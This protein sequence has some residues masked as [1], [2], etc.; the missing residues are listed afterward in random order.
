MVLLVWSLSAP[1]KPWILGTHAFWWKPRALWC[2]RVPFRRVLEGGSPGGGEELFPHADTMSVP[3]RYHKCE[4]ENYLTGKFLKDTLNFNVPVF[5]FF[6]LF[7]IIELIVTSG[8][9]SM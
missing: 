6:S 9:H 7:E 2:Q 4:G 1:P 8:G 5:F 3:I